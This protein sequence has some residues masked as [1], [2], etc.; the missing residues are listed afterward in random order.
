M[1]PSLND[2]RTVAATL[3]ADCFVRLPFSTITRS[4]SFEQFFGPDELEELV[5]GQREDQVHDGE[6]E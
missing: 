2:S 6:R 1:R 4:H 5:L 3:R